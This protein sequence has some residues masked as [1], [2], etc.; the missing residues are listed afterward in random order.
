MKPFNKYILVLFLLNLL[1]IATAYY[2]F[3][4]TKLKLLFSDIVI[5]S[6]SFSIIAIITLMIFFRGQSGEPGSQTMHTL[7]SISLK[8]LLDMILALLWFIVAK[9]NS[10]TSVLL[11]FV[12]YL[13]LSLFSIWVILKT[14]KKRSL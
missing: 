2:L 13:E 5:L 10:L 6:S 11:F 7:A 9:K 12:L 14:L 8:F 1:F 4:T 3:S